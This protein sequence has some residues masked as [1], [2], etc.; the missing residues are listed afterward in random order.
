MRTGQTA[1]SVK[2]EEEEEEKD[3]E[4]SGRGTIEVLSGY[5]RYRVPLLQRICNNTLFLPHRPT[6]S[7]LATTE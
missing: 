6:D 4:Q 3:V 7:H 5:S 1:Y 2:V